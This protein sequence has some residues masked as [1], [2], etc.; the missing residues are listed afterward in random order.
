MAITR[1]EFLTVPLL[2]IAPSCVPAEDNTIDI[3]E[4]PQPRFYDYSGDLDPKFPKIKRQQTPF[5]VLHCTTGGEGDFEDSLKGLLS[6]GVNAH[7]LIRR[8]GDVYRLVPEEF[9]AFHSGLSRWDGYEDLNLFS[10]GVEFVGTNREPFTPE[11]YASFRHIYRGKDGIKERYRVEDK[12]VVPHSYVAYFHS[13]NKQKPRRGRRADPGFFFDRHS[14][15]LFGAPERDMDIEKGQIQP[16]ENPTKLVVHPQQRE[17]A[18]VDGEREIVRYV[19]SIDARGTGYM[20]RGEFSVV[21]KHSDVIQSFYGNHALYVSQDGRTKDFMIHGTPHTDVRTLNLWAR[22]F[23]H[24]INPGYNDW[25]R[26]RNVAMHNAEIR[27]VYDN[28]LVGTPV[29]VR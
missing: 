4:T 14:A 11:Q 15:G 21:G 17:M 9:V 10:L 6:P 2:A 23:M 7:Y 27:H 5:V 29:D 8:N 3:D 19:I 25:T 13:G 22:N 12:N 20:E 18:I 26:D 28:I 1:R 24:S 16:P